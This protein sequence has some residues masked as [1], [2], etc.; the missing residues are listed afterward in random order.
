[1]RIVTISL[2]LLLAMVHS[3]LWLGKGGVPRVMELRSRLNLQRTINDADRE[4]N[5]Q[6]G[7]EVRDLKDGLEMVEEQARFDLGMVKPHEIL[8]QLIKAPK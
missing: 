2:V 5:A 6:L 1:M 4:R 7:A 3:E 8:V